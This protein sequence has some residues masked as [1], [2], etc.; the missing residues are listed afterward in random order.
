MINLCLYL[1]CQI[2]LGSEFEGGVV[3]QKGGNVIPTFLLAHTFQELYFSFSGSIRKR[4]SCKQKG[5][6]LNQWKLFDDLMCPDG[7][8]CFAAARFLWQVEEQ[9]GLCLNSYFH[10]EKA[11]RGSGFAGGHHNLQI[12]PT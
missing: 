3:M 7:K 6:Q 9:N 8:P 2:M 1:G 5:K 11:L 4:K 12:I 10:C